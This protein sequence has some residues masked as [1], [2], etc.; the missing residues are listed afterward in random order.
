MVCRAIQSMASAP[1]DLASV[2]SL[3]EKN[4]GAPR[5]IRFSEGWGPEYNSLD[6]SLDGSYTY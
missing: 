6:S 3:L 4:S 1:V 2:G 5:W